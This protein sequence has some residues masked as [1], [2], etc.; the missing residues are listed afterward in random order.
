MS[1]LSDQPDVTEVIVDRVKP[2]RF[3]EVNGR[4]DETVALLNSH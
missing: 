2:L 4:Y 1:I 3:S